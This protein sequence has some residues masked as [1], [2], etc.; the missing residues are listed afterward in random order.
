MTLPFDKQHEM[1]PPPDARFSW[2]LSQASVDVLA[3]LFLRLENVSDV[4]SAGCMTAEAT[5]AMLTDLREQ[6][7]RA[8][9]ADPC[10]DR[11]MWPRLEDVR[12]V[13][14]SSN[15]DEREVA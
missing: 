15:S 13:G 4:I 10:P 3:H 2:E 6:T 12:T 7:V 14:K 11:A 8:G 1:V 5:A 9:A